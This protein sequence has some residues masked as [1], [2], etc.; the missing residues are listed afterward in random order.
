MFDAVS[1]ANLVGFW[2]AEYSTKGCVLASYWGEG[3]FACE[4]VLKV[5]EPFGALFKGG[6]KPIFYEHEWVVAENWIPSF[7]WY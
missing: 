5:N 2:G 4:Y 7:S 1:E 6:F 3:V